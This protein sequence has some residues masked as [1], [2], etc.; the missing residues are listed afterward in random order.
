M[1]RR[2]RPAV[3]VL[4]A[5][6]AATFATACGGDATGP[7]NPAQSSTPSPSTTSSP[8]SEPPD[9]IEVIDVGEG[10]VG[11][12]AA[13][14]GSV[15]VVSSGSG[16]VSRIPPGA[17]EPDLV[18]RVTGTPLRAV[19]ARGSLWVSLF[20]GLQLQRLDAA[21]GRLTGGVAAGA[22]PEGVAAG[23]GSIWLVEQDAGRLV[24]VDP[25]SREVLARVDIGVG[26]RLVMAGSD[27]L[28]VAA[29]RDDRLLR[30]DPTSLEVTRDR[31][32]S[33][34]AR[35]AW[36]SSTVGSGSRARSPTRWS[37]SIRSR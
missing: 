32:G 7:G 31:R 30:V 37:P 11:L 14:D 10:P 33:A 16:D 29:F 17:T 22:G 20:R 36:P 34:P 2:S 28:W 24:R 27:A 23:F 8:S 25:R 13:D 21:T 5:T 26:A 4:A 35:R 15:W 18:V 9:G 19:V 6:L 1:P 3:A 12:A